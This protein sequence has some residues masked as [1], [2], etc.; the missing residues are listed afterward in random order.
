MMSLWQLRSGLSVNALY[1]LCAMFKSNFNNFV[2][3]GLTYKKLV[4]FIK[5]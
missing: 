3:N 1:N 5:L 4:L 2:K